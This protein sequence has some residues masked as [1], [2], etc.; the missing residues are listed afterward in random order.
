MATAINVTFKSDEIEM[1]MY[2]ECISHS[3]RVCFVKDCISFFM[4]YGHMEKQLKEM[5]AQESNKKA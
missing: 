1:K 2:S 3:G 4:K 5:L